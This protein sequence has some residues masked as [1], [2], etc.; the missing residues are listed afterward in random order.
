[1][2]ITSTGGYTEIAKVLH[3]SL[4]DARGNYADKHSAATNAI[5]ATTIRMADLFAKDNPRFDRVRFYENVGIIPS[6]EI[7]NVPIKH[8]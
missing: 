2:A 7:K 8:S 3:D 1:M 5:F 4:T 6:E